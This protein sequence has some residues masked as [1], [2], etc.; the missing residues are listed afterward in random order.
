MDLD[1]GVDQ[2]EGPEAGG[3]VA[4]VGVEGTGAG[5][6]EAEGVGGVGAQLVAAGVGEGDA[7]RKVEDDEYFRLANLEQVG[8][9]EA[10]F[11]RRGV[12]VDDGGGGRGEGGGQCQK[13]EEEDGG[14]GMAACSAAGVPSFRRSEA[15]PPRGSTRV[16]LGIQIRRRRRQGRAHR[17]VEA[18]LLLLCCLDGY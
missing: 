12:H 3:G 13:M 4:V 17:R 1:V 14:G 5:I 18:G 10:G 15:R 16:W 11:A 6:L 2:A 8:G 9:A 7:L